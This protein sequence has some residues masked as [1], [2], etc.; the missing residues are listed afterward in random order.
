VRMVILGGDDFIGSALPREIL[1]T[2][3]WDVVNLGLSGHRLEQ[4]DGHRRFAYI[5][6]D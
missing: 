6:G 5:Q 3:D 4:F 1:A 2:R